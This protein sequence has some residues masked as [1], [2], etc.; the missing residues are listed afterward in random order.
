MKT[1]QM[2]IPLALALVTA[3]AKPPQAEVDAARAALDSARTAEAAEYAPESLAAAEDALAALDAEIQAQQGRFFLIRSYGE[4]QTKAAAAREAA[5]KA[6][7]DAATAREQ[8]RVESEGLLAQ[9]S[10]QLTEASSLL[11]VAPTGKGTA[12]D[13]AALKADLQAATS[14]IK[15]AEQAY[16]AGQYKEA[17]AKATAAIATIGTVKQAIESARQMRERR[18]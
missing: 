9:A 5:E 12:A 10:A 3:C 18:S 17:Q 15:E 11:A 4:A 13:I 1:K 6:A 8:V 14:T 2:I 7:G 16:S